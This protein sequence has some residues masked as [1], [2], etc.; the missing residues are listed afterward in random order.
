MQRPQQSKQNFRTNYG[1][2]NVTF[3]PVE[4]Q[5]PLPLF[6][7]SL[8]IYPHHQSIIMLQ[9]IMQR[10]PVTYATSK[11][12]YKQGL[13]LRICSDYRYVNT[14]NLCYVR[15][16]LCCVYTTIKVTYA[17]ITVTYMHRLL[18]HICND[19]TVTYMQRLPLRMQR[20]LLRLQRLPLSMK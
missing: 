1:A 11:V 5:H 2:A 19:Y 17:T 15:N 10:F 18:L 7:E 13:P 16:N 8:P 3:A 20:I 12:S 4:Y 14:I 6:S 9:R